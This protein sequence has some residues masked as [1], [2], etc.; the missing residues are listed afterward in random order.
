MEYRSVG[1]SGLKVS[2]ICL[3]TM[4]FGAR[5]DEPEA[6]RI[7][8]RAR[9]AGVNFIDTADYYAEG[10]GEAMV[11]DLIASDRDQWVV[12]TKVGF[13]TGP[14]PNEDGTSAIHV[15]ASVEQSL[16]QAP[17]R[18]DRP[19]LR[20]PGRSDDA[21]RRDAARRRRPHRGRQGPLLGA[22]ER[23]RLAPR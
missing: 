19:L 8:R 15:R 9:D 13:R 1:E 12:A 18:Q 17:H 5:T 6:D 7:V 20:P 2:P 22:L 3:G 11:G 4:M 23:P 14:G 16:G 21:A 10:R